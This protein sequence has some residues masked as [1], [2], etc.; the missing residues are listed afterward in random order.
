MDSW[1]VRPSHSGGQIL[2]LEHVQRSRDVHPRTLRNHIQENTLIPVQFVPAMRFLVFDFSV[3]CQ[4]CFGAVEGRERKTG[5]RGREEKRREGG[6]GREKRGKGRE[7][8]EA[9]QASI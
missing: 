2:A 6:K 8:K 3:C 5:L 1:R 4:R 9:Y 7:V